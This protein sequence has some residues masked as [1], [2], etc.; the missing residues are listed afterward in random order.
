MVVAVVVGACVAFVALA[1][2]Q[3][4]GADPLIIDI[5]YAPG[6]EPITAAHDG[7][8]YDLRAAQDITYN[9]WEVVEIPLGVCM[10]LPPGYE[11][12]IKP[13]SS[14]SRKRGLAFVDSGLIDNKFCGDD[15]WWGSTW[16]AMRPGRIRKN[17]RI[18][19]FRIVERQPRVAFNVVRTM[20]NKN[21]GGYGSTG[22]F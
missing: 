15:D 9:R 6:V 8:W 22:D 17:E 11:A 2:V 10:K 18:C 7:E 20:V 5:K 12:I 14:S 19:Q 4:S 21:R 13:R 16:F 3:A 1:L